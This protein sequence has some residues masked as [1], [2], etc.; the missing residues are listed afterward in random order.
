MSNI[1]QLK[2]QLVA[3]C[4]AMGSQEW[5]KGYGHVS[6]RIPDSDLF[7]MPKIVGLHQVTEEDIWTFN[8]KGEKIEGG[9]GMAPSE[10]P[11]HSC[12]Y[13]TRPDV[14]SVCHVHPHYSV[15]LTLV[16]E[17]IK[18]LTQGFIKYPKG[19]PVFHRLGL[20]VTEKLGE[21]VAET[22]G[23]NRAVLL[24]AHGAVSVGK[25]IVE[26]VTTMVALED[27]AR[28]QVEALMIG[29]PC[30]LTPEELQDIK[31]TF[32]RGDTS[33]LGYNRAWDYLLSQIKK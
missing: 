13:R 14:V 19:V 25:D 20:I 24:R 26:C 17:T 5:V 8:L 30:Y 1:K 12:I 21:A 4:R 22:L 6:V 11:I 23:Q 32:K 15:L 29:K 18:P 3:G 2:E 7:L 33:S 10:T 27:M 28:Y 31:E 9:S 16:G